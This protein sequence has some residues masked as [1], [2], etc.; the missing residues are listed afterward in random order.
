MEVKEAVRTAKAH[1]TELFADENI[2]E[3]GLEEV[4][5]DPVNN[6]WKIT[7]GFSRHW[8]S[9]H[10]SNLAAALADRRPARSYKVVVINDET[11]Q[12]DSLTDRFLNGP[13]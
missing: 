11:G 4:N 13:N 6:R 5:F 2:R 7:I 9:V 3:V 10:K 1:V 8:D 12:A